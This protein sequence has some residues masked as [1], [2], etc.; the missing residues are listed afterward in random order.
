MDSKSEKVHLACDE[1]RSRKLKCSGE[2]PQCS[3]C[4]IETMHCVYSTQKR[5]GRPRKRKKGEVEDDPDTDSI[6]YENGYVPNASASNG[7][8][9]PEPATSDSYMIPPFSERDFGSFGIDDFAFDSSRQQTNGH[10]NGPMQHTNAP[11]NGH[12]AGQNSSPAQQL[13]TPPVPQE[14]PAC[15]CL[16]NAYLANS[17]L[18]SLTHTFPFVLPQI[19]AAI[20]TAAEIMEC[21]YCPK[22]PGSAMQNM[23]TLATLLTSTV[24]HL[25]K[26]LSSIDDEATKVEASGGTKRFQMGD[27][28]PGTRHMH[29]GTPDCPARFPIELSSNEWRSLAKNV[30][31]SQIV[32]T[33][34]DVT[35]LLGVIDRLNKRQKMWH[36][37]KEKTSQMLGNFSKCAAD[38]NGEYTCMRMI[39]M[40][41]EMIDVLEW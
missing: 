25:R 32:G 7:Y 13:W 30:V 29:T 27:D 1:C 40:I 5:M 14:N 20:T 37:N 24:D 9:M 2:R 34:E 6:L 31:K 39:R 18:Q 12:N 41:R 35:T 21:E 8:A 26:I 10:A 3:R 11:G 28:S 16:S 23:F 4:R 22:D 38:E 15:A 36:A 17:N 33:V 19:R